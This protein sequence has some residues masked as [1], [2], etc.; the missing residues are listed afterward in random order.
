[1]TR[2]GGYPRQ[3]RFFIY[4]E[5]RSEPHLLHIR[6]LEKISHLLWPQRRRENRAGCPDTWRA[7]TWGPLA[8]SVCFLGLRIEVFCDSRLSWHKPDHG[9]PF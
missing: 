7:T 5:A 2:L 4:G 8:V 9:P 1:M 3:T 6:E